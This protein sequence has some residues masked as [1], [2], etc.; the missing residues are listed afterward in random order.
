MKVKK[1]NGLRRTNEGEAKA[2]ALREGRTPKRPTLNLSE[3]WS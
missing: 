1:T 3:V 2:I